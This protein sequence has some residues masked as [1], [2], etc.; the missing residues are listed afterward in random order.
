MTEVAT[1]RKSPAQYQ[2]ERIR[3]EI[4][5]NLRTTL[6]ENSC[7]VLLFL[8]SVRE[9]LSRLKEVGG[10]LGGYF[11][12]RHMHVTQETPHCA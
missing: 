8:P 6:P 3:R 10:S 4:H 1:M 7:G 11:E 9:T 2:V 12:Y 5:V